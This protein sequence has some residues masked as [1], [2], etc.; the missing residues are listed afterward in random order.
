M[1]ATMMLSDTFRIALMCGKA[2]VLGT[3]LATT[4]WAQTVVETPSGNTAV[5]TDPALEPTAPV[6]GDPAIL[7]AARPGGSRLSC[8]SEKQQADMAVHGHSPSD[9]ATEPLVSVASRYIGRRLGVATPKR[10]TRRAT[11][12]CSARRS[13]LGRNVRSRCGSDVGC[14]A[15]RIRADCPEE[16]RLCAGLV[17]GLARRKLRRLIP[18]GQTTL[19]VINA[20]ASGS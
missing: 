9:G 15:T 4:S 13:R 1:M 2:A 6:G 12:P 7:S 17:F 11:T 8:P 19:T 14:P 5:V 10:E 20:P 18:V 16:S 3:M